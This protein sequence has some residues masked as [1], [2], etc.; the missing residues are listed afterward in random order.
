[1]KPNRQMVLLLHGGH[2]RLIP[3]HIGSEEKEQEAGML[4][5]EAMNECV[6]GKPARVFCWYGFTFVSA[7]VV[8]FYFRDEPPPREDRQ[9]EYAKELL[10]ILKAESRK[11]DE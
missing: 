7:W 6:D 11:G 10:E 9:A 4:L 2:E 5:L 3:I 8:G 1:M